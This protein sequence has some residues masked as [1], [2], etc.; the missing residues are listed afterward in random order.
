VF[1][2]AAL[3]FVGTSHGVDHAREL[4]ESTVTGILDD[5]SAMIS[6]SRNKKRLSQS[7]QLCQRA[8]FVN[9]DQAAKARNIRR[10]NRYQSP[11]YVLSAQDAPPGLGETQC[12]YTTIA[13]QCPAVPASEVGHS[14]LF[15]RTTATSGL[16]PVNGHSQ[17]RRACL[18]A[19]NRCRRAYTVTQA[20]LGVAPALASQ[21]PTLVIFSERDW[22]GE[23]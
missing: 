1:G 3:D 13:D 17:D 12:S 8:F 4:N 6:D 5:A 19:T 18:N 22:N 21:R 15:D 16:P 11:L 20:A 2:H 23:A 9:P 10:Q 14:R 7:F